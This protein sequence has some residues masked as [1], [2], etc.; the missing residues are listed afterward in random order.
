MTGHRDLAPSPWIVRFAPLVA[1]GARILDLAC[2]HGRHARWFAS[3]GASVLAVDR[4][5]AALAAL[6]CVPGVET[7]EVDLEAGD[8]PL[9]GTFDA[10]VVTHYLHRPSF[11]TMLGSIAADGVLLYETFAQGNERYGS[12][13]NPAF[14]LAQDELLERVRG[15]LT[16]VAFEQGSVHQ[17]GRHAVVQRIAAVGTARGWPPLLA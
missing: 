2:G 1:A 6:A 7:R 9:Q 12:P 15:R 17:G 14:L 5:T 4:D 11:A 8:W 13:S 3:R 10:I 16:V